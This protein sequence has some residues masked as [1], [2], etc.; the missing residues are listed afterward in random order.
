[1]LQNGA[2]QLNTQLSGVTGVGGLALGYSVTFLIELSLLL[3]ILRRRWGDIDE[4]HLGQTA[5]RTV[6]A[7]VVM[8]AAVLAADAVFGAMGWHE[9]GV[10][11]TTLRIFG[12]AGVGAVTFVIA[13]VLLGLREIRALPAMV[14]RRRAALQDI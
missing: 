10:I 7:T 11:L 14:L 3:V 8:G 12:L 13:G 1:V 9:A 6:T 4:R 5:L 2:E